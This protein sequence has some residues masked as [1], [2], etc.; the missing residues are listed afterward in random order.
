MQ[1]S[2]IFLFLYEHRYSVLTSYFLFIIAAMAFYKSRIENKIFTINSEIKVNKSKNSEAKKESKSNEANQSNEKNHY[3]TILEEILINVKSN[4][5]ILFE[6]IKTLKFANESTKQR[7][8]DKSHMEEIL[9]KGHDYEKYVAE[10][11]KSIGYEVSLN[12][13]IHGKKDDGIDIICKRNNELI[14]VQCKNWNVKSRYRITHLILKAFIGCCSEYTNKNQI[15]N[16]KVEFHFITSN[17]ILDASA[18]K[19]LAE[20]TTLKY[21]IL[22]FN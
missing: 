14:L 2:I 19:Y 9:K 11:Y 20:S 5:K 10:H 15:L 18:K 21:K 16:K 8:R 3:G 13:I 7:T 17:N 4:Y 12:G 1:E 6:E 22:P